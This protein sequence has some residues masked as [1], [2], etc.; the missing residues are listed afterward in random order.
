MKK[1][2]RGRMERKEFRVIR[3]AAET[4]QYDTQKKE[5]HSNSMG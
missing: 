2:L 3:A 4:G 1:T 5:R